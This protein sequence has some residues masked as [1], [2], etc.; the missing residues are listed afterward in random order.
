MFDYEFSRKENSLIIFL[1]VCL[2]SL[3]YYN[4]AYLNFKEQMKLYNTETLENDIMIEEAR[5][6]SKKSMLKEIEKKSD[7]NKVSIIP[8]YNSQGDEIKFLTDVLNRNEGYDISFIWDDPILNKN[9]VRRNVSVSFIVPSYDAIK[10]IMGEIKNSDRRSIIVGSSI[11]RE[12]SGF[13][14]SFNL[15]FFE[16]VEGDIDMAG[17]DFIEEPMVEEDDNE[18]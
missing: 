1:A 17:L 4:F 10:S 7:S 12:K 15:T 5:A 13:H 9:I 11:V 14:V 16:S 2:L 18:E 3:F 6:F 8:A